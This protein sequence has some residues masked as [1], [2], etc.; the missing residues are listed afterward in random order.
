MSIHKNYLLLSTSESELVD[1]LIQEAFNQS[2]EVMG[3]RLLGDDRCEIV[4]EALAT[5]FLESRKEGL[6]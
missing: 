4:V 2:A 3:Y 1:Q 5:W 6:S